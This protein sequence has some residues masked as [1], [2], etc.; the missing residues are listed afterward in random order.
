L[1]ADRAEKKIKHTKNKK[2]K[3]PMLKGTQTPTEISWLWP[4]LLLVALG[5]LIFWQIKDTGD[6]D[7]D[8]LAT[9]IKTRYY[10]QNPYLVVDIP[11]PKTAT[12]MGFVNGGDKDN[13]LSLALLPLPYTVPGGTRKVFLEKVQ[14]GPTK[15]ERVRVWHPIA[16][17]D[18][19][20]FNEARNKNLGAF[21]DLNIS[22]WNTKDKD[23]RR[24]ANVG[25]TVPQVDLQSSI[26]DLIQDADIPWE[27][28]ENI[29]KEKSDFPP[30]FD[31]YLDPEFADVEV[32]YWILRFA[33]PQTVTGQTNVNLLAV[34][35][36]VVPTGKV[37]EQKASQTLPTEFRFTLGATEE[38]TEDNIFGVVFK[39]GNVVVGADFVATCN[40]ED[41]PNCALLYKYLDEQPDPQPAFN[42]RGFNGS[43]Y[44]PRKF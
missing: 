23:A 28:S 14:V 6:D 30:K 21:N 11:V 26:D 32:P 44:R 42:K 12:D 35:Y 37:E 2:K 38:P 33:P 17:Y 40:A 24:V 13:R 25:I 18:P 27:V 15:A 22:F 4:L 20:Q 34:R 8:K 7:D 19:A 9:N 1:A 39:R 16:A 10:L 29:P 3:P 5:G 36:H 43:V 41:S 31:F